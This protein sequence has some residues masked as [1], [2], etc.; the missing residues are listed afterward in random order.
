M[1]VRGKLSL[2]KK[3]GALQLSEIDE[4]IGFTVGLLDLSLP[5]RAFATQYKVTIRDGMSP[6]LEFLL[7]AVK[8]LGEVPEDEIGA[9]F[10]YSERELEHVLREGE[11]SGFVSFRQGS[12]VL[13]GDGKACFGD[14]EEP[15]ILKVE[16]RTRELRLDLL[17][18]APAQRRYLTKFELC[19]PELSL[20][21]AVE[22]GAFATDVPEAFRRFFRELGAEK[23][24]KREGDRT[25][26]SVDHVHPGPRHS[27]VVP[28]ALVA[29]P[30]APDTPEVEFYGWRPDHEIRDR[31]EIVAA[32][33]QVVDSLAV[34]RNSV[35]DELATDTLSRLAIGND[36][37]KYQQTGPARIHLW[38][39]GLA[40]PKLADPA[41]T[42]PISG[43]FYSD[44][45]RRFLLSILESSLTKYSA[46]DRIVL[47][48]PTL[49]HWGAN[50]TLV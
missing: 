27:A 3:N 2:P 33:Q 28:I 40:T 34:P 14:R 50:G 4:E 29:S 11:E 1:I 10:G 5:C 23:R 36:V 24:D 37:V 17:S 7:R 9:F 20:P 8:S 42:V 22:R 46:P 48:C 16:R 18:L 47:L 19:L 41:P 45:N 49:P 15:S 6:S 44:S 25:L 38:H 26:Y 32:V 13:T 30:N 43:P 21:R 35:D 39:E 12:I 31:P